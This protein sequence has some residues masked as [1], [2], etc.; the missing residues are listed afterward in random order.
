MKLW[1]TT[2]VFKYVYIGISTYNILLLV[3]TIYHYVKL[4]M[5]IMYTYNKYNYMP[6]FWEFYGVKPNFVDIDYPKH[7]QAIHCE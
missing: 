5:N 4:R 6:S 7:I 3:L 1:K 2:Q